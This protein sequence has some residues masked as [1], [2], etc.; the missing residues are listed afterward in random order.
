MGNFYRPPVNPGWDDFGSRLEHGVENGIALAIA[1][2]QRRRDQAKDDAASRQADEDRARHLQMEDAEMGVIPESD[3]YESVPSLRPSLAAV[4]SGTLA[5]SPATGGLESPF[6]PWHPQEYERGGA[7]AGMPGI[8]G[9]APV[10]TERQLRPGVIQAG[11]LFIDPS[12][13]L[14][15]RRQQAT[16]QAERAQDEAQREQKRLQVRTSLVATGMTP[17]EADRRAVAAA[18]GVTLPQTPEEIQAATRARMA[19]EEP[20]KTAEAER[21]LKRTLAIVAARGREGQGGARGTSPAQSRAARNELRG[22]AED[23]AY[24]L[25]RSDPTISDQE[26]FDYLRRADV[27]GR[28]LPFNDIENAIAAAQGRFGREQGGGP[29]GQMRERAR[30]NASRKR[31]AE[32]AHPAPTSAPPV[33]GTTPPPRT[34]PAGPPQGGGGN[35]SIT[36]TEYAALRQRGF[37]DQQ[38]RARFQVK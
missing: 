36:Q 23:T 32:H 8:F 7:D 37:S 34:P 38:I 10:A 16:A 29:G 14:A 20:Y 31:Q 4:A 24:R 18:Y 11:G 33:A 12:R 6:R 35:S 13:S 3:A 27:V 25:I 9:P 1:G 26:V 17:Q 30:L 28:D 5:P 22:T 19:A 2:K 15:F 21:T